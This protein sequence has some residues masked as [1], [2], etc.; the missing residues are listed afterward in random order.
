[1]WYWAAHAM[2]HLGDVIF[3]GSDRKTVQHL[4]F[5]SATTLADA[6]DM[7]SETVG[8]SPRIT[9]M[10]CPPLMLADVR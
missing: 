2:D 8:R 1:M 10:R 5:R 7:A 9:A 4:G 3:V 6:L